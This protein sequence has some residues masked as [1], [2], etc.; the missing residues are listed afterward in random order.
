MSTL[1]ER[2]RYSTKNLSEKLPKCWL[3]SALT[4]GLVLDPVIDGLHRGPGPVSPEATFAA[5]IDEDEAEHEDEDDPDDDGDDDDARKE[6]L[7]LHRVLEG[8][9]TERIQI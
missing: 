6:L 4:F 2:F 3:E 8:Y 9:K 5:T 7:L 1:K